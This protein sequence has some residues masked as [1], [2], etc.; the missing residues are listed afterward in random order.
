MADAL[1]MV[2]EQTGTTFTFSLCEW[3]WVSEM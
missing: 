2:A 1:A 3:G